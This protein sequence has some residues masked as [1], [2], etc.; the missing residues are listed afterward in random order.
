[1]K[2]VLLCNG[3]V[4]L[5]IISGCQAIAVLKYHPHQRRRGWFEANGSPRLT[6]GCRGLTILRTSKNSSLDNGA[7]LIDAEAK[8]L[9]VDHSYAT[10]FTKGP[11]ARCLA[12]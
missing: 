9:M 6:D 4:P 3:N 10:L 1:M 11:G 8:L 12:L 7:E 5:I 2:L